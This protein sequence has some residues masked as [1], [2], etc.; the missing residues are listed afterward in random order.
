MSTGLS[1]DPGTG[2]ERSDGAPL[3][4]LAI[5]HRNSLRQWYQRITGADADPGVLREAKGV[6]VDGLLMAIADGVPGAHAALLA[7]EEYGSSALRRANGA[8]LVTA[9][10][11]E[12]S[13]QSEFSFEYGDRF[14][15]H[16]AGSGAGTVKAL[17]RYNPGGDAGR[18]AR[19]RDRLRMLAEWLDGHNV[20]LMLE[21]LVPPEPEQLGRL[22]G[23]RARFDNELRPE[24]TRHAI[25][26]L[27]GAGLAPRY[28]KLEG[29]PTA[30]ACE[31]L[32]REAA[33]TPSTQC[34][35]LG[36]GE[37]A[38]AVERW[39][40]A[41]APVRGFGG[42]AIGRTI[43]AEPLAAWLT[44]RIRRPEAAASIAAAYRH[45]ADLYRSAT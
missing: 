19:S 24:L 18:N 35:V 13:G 43:W 27:A 16:I 29:Q 7:D 6:V 11:V 26:E 41:A 5:D 31:L 39:L 21:L 9:L 25:R 30:A 10:A 15:E 17:V 3:F 2:A 34:L 28:W 38:A 40:S 33:V 8:G 32:A 1:A 42:F 44:G 36:R 20:P 14:G 22:G 12:R 23:D 37:D 45:F 4:V